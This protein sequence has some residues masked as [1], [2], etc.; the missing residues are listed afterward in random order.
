M[1]SA[2]ETMIDGAIDLF[3]RRGV[4]GTSLRDVV[5]HSGAPRGSIYHHF[6]GGKDELAA[7]A[8]AR[9]GVLT[10]GLIT[11]LASAGDPGAAVTELVEIWCRRLERSDFEQGCPVAASA[12]AAD[13]TPAARE[14]AAAAFAG[15]SGLLREAFAR[16]GVPLE[17]AEARA[18]LAICAIEGALLV[19]RAQRSVEPLRSAGRSL[20]TMWGSA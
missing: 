5:E 10:D 18:N 6:P 13:E 4:A 15:W 17:E 2:R 14:A 19:S 20:V 11:K 16:S 9:A 12:L 7:A 8:A 3:A 1:T